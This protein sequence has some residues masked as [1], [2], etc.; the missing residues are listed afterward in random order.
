MILVFSIGF[1]SGLVLYWLTN[2]V[3]SV[4]NHYL[5]PGAERKKKGDLNKNNERSKINNNEVN[6]KN[7]IRATDKKEKESKVVQ[8]GSP[9]VKKKKS[10]KKKKGAK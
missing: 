9:K 6:I 3:F 8:T 4:G 1:P 7:N 5:M 10:K 2:S